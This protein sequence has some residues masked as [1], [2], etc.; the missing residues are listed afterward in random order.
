MDKLSESAPGSLHL[1]PSYWS[2]SW[3]SDLLGENL[4]LSPKHLIWED[5]VKFYHHPES[6]L[7]SLNK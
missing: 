6:Q 5:F 7:L 3:E 4:S 2:T 1:R